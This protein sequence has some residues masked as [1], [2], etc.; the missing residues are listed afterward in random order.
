M[1]ATLK[2]ATAAAIPFESD[3]FDV[4]YSFGVLH[5]TDNTV[6]CLSECYRVLKP[7]GVL[8]LG[9]YHTFSFFHA[10]TIF[11][12]GI[13]RGELR[14]LGYRGLMSLIESGADGVTI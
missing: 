14:R 4:V 7:G 9:L 6:R 10:Y 1:R 12:N 8:I 2:D 11:V 13:L 3:F 5:H